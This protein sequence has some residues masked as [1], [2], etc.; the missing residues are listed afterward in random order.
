MTYTFYIFLL[1][2]PTLT[3][4]HSLAEFEPL[5]TQKQKTAKMAAFVFGRGRKIRTLDTR[6]WRPMLYQ[7]SY[8]PI[9]L[10]SL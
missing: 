6:F 10:S 8:T 5:P 4:N 2:P 3:M 1:L 9:K 7:L